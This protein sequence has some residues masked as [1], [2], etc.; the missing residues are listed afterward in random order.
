[1]NHACTLLDSREREEQPM[2]ATRC[3][4]PTATSRPPFSKRRANERPAGHIMA[5]ILLLLRMLLG[6][7]ALMAP[8]AATDAED[9][10]S[11]AEWFKFYCVD[12]YSP[13]QCDAAL[14]FIQ[15]TYGLHYITSL[16]SNE[17]P[18]SYLAS[19]RMVI[20]GGRQMRSVQAAA[21]G[22]RN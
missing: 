20:E 16:N 9:E 21:I 19:L 18:Q 12:Y 14:V 5:R 6:L 2:G 17:D 10:M 7:F 13:T 4:T 3:R 11:D 15:K 1:M 8:A 22:R